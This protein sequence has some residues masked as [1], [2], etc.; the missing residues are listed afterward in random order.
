MISHASDTPWLVAQAVADLR[1]VASA[2]RFA[3]SGLAAEPGPDSALWRTVFDED[4]EPVER[5]VATARLLAKTLKTRDALEDWL[6]AWEAVAPAMRIA[7]SPVSAALGCGFRVARD[8]GLAYQDVRPSATDCATLDHDTVIA[9][10]LPH[11]KSLSEAEREALA[12]HDWDQDRERHRDALDRLLGRDDCRL[13]QGEAYNPAEAVELCGY[14]PQHPQFAAATALLLIWSLEDQGYPYGNLFSRWMSHHPR[15]LE[16]P[17][18]WKT[19]IL[20][21]FRR[22]YETSESFQTDAF[23]RSL[24]E[25]TRGPRHRTRPVATIPWRLDP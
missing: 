11:L 12:A 24:D 17:Q 3:L 14:A 9:R 1:A 2:P 15:Y 23:K 19:V 6:W 25:S 22:A 20:A 10:L 18:K 13:L 8:L 7:P 16:L 21:G 4:A 5:C